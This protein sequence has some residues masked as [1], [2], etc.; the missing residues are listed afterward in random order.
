MQRARIVRIIIAVVLVGATVFGCVWL[1]IPPL[2]EGRLKEY[3]P[4]FR[5]ESAETGVSLDLLLAIA[6]AESA[7][8]NRAVSSAGAVGLMQV[9]PATARWLAAREGM[10]YEED[11]L[12]VPA[13]NV[14][15]GA[16]YLAYLETK[17]VGEW[18]IAAYNAGEGAV[19]QWIECGVALEDVPYRETREYLTKVRKL[20]KAY[21][22]RGYSG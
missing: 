9:M 6:N 2:Y 3:L 11:M 16:A 13:Y 5:L 4:I 20:S 22:R 14:H 8:D 10:A 1:A 21:R 19:A 18:V 12:W 7:F 17:F 15:L